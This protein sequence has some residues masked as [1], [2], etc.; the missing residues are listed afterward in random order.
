MG[1]REMLEID[2]KTPEERRSRAAGRAKQPLNSNMKYDRLQ[3]S[4][5]FINS[6]FGAVLKGYKAR[7]I[8][9]NLEGLSEL[10]QRHRDL[11]LLLQMIQN[12]FEGASDIQRKNSGCFIQEQHLHIL[13]QLILTQATFNKKF[14]EK[15]NGNGNRS[16]WVRETSRIV[17]MGG[18]R[19]ESR[20]EEMV[21]DFHRDL[22]EY[23]LRQLQS[24]IIQL[25]EQTMAPVNP[26]LVYSS[27]QSSQQLH[28]KIPILND[29]V[30][31]TKN[32]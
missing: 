32:F 29:S 13:N 5:R 17:R 24:E 31:T 21:G 23:E 6:K 15:M 2:I 27:L 4:L 18:S 20:F 1:S 14:E 9:Y 7:C 10:R 22:Q 3:K 28:D 16:S 25:P 26:Q 11:G 12:V 30:Q 19:A 8:F